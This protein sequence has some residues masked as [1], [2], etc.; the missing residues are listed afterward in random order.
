M[1]LTTEQIDAIVYAAVLAGGEVGYPPPTNDEIKELRTDTQM[2]EA[3]IRFSRYV[4]ANPAIQ[5][6]VL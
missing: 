1:E 3:L 5:L 2:Q 6:L 4:A